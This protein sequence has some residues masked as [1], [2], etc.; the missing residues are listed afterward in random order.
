[1][2]G[3]HGQLGAGFPDGLGRQDPDCLPDLNLFTMGK[4]P[5]VALAAHAV[6]GFAG[7]YRSNSQSGNAGIFNSFDMI[8]FKQLTGLR[9]EFI[10]KGVM[11]IFGSH[12][13]QDALA[14]ALNDLPAFH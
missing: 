8:F 12:T 5:A 3:P 13:P 1:M 11:D 10:R 9:Q 4:I 2:K 7:Q 14:Q 6:F